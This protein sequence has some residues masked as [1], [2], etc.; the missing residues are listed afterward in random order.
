MYNNEFFIKNKNQVNNNI[1][2]SLVKFALYNHLNNVAN[3]L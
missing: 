1:L 3:L 2:D